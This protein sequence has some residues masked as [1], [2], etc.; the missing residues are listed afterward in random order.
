MV[1][2]VLLNDGFFVSIDS[3]QKAAPAPTA[4]PPTETAPAVPPV[5][6]PGQHL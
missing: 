6:A 5:S 3:Y 1:T 4:A 2:K